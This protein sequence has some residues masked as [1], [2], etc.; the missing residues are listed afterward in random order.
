MSE[1]MNPA[2]WKRCV[3][4]VDF[5]VSACL[6]ESS[7]LYYS[8]DGHPLFDIEVALFVPA[9]A[10]RRDENSVKPL[11]ARELVGRALLGVDLIA[12]VCDQFVLFIEDRHAA[13]E[14]ADH[15]VGPANVERGGQPELIVLGPV[16]RF[17]VLAFGVVTVNVIRAVAVGNVKIPVRRDGDAGRAELI[18]ILVNAGFFGIALH[19]DDLAVGRKF[20][21]LMTGEVGQVDELLAALLANQH[22]VRAVA[23]LVGLPFLAERFD[24]LA[25]LVEDDDRVLGVGVEINAILRIDLHR[26][27]SAAE[28]HPFGQLPP[29]ANPF[30]A[31]IARAENDRIRSGVSGKARRRDCRNGDAS[32]QAVKKPAASD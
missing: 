15:Q 4:R 17:D 2:R 30:V 1:M 14:I 25:V 24:E 16:E 28:L 12:E 31:V 7:Q 32:A 19:P 8:S 9:D 3:P 27:V 6:L 20:G 13:A 10:V 21:A 23:F 18:F 26:A 11:L 5:I 22:S 29:S